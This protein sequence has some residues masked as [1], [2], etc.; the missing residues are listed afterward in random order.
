MAR[1]GF[2]LETKGKY[3]TISTTRRG[4]CEGCAD[5]SSCSFENALGKGTPEEVTA[6][7]SIEAKAGDTVEFDL[8]GHTELKISLIVWIVPLIGI[9]IGAFAGSN[10]HGHIGLSKDIGTL[11]GVVVGFLA[12]FSLV[13]FLDRRSAKSRVLMPLILRR[14]SK[15]DCSGTSPTT[16]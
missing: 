16:H 13:V 2:I 4:I 9:L 3:A 11:L 14:I 15:S 5:Q 7:N 8:I 1:V 6:L 12:A 10:L